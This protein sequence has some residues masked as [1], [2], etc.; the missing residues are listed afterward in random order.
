MSDIPTPQAGE[1]WIYRW[2]DTGE[3]T[4]MPVPE[5]YAD[6]GG[7]EWF[8]KHWLAGNLHKLDEFDEAAPVSEL[9][10]SRSGQESEKERA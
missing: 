5:M 7:V 1:K 10:W 2:E 6:E 4:P 9:C 3:W 8:R